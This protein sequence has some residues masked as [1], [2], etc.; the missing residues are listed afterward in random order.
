ME[1]HDGLELIR[2]ASSLFLIALQGWTLLKGKGDSKKK[3]RKH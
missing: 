2:T 1:L 3:R